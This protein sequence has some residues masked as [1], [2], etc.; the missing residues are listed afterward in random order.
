RWTPST[1][2]RLPYTTLFRSWPECHRRG[3]D[4]YWPR[5][6]CCGP[7]WP[8]SC[9][10]GATPGW[11]TASGG[12]PPALLLPTPAPCRLHCEYDWY[13]KRDRKST[14][15]NSSHVKISYA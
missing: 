12:L 10:C 15:L 7:S 2:P 1:P 6:G 14:R 11:R 5:Y 4:Q 9:T 8:A 13:A 3:P